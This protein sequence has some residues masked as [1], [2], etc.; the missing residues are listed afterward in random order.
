M[1]KILTVILAL[2]ALFV[3]FPAIVKADVKEENEIVKKV[4]MVRIQNHLNL[5]SV[6]DELTEKARIR[7]EEAAQKWSHTRPDGSEWSTIGSDG[8]NLCY[9]R[10]LS[11][12]VDLWMNSD[13]HR[14][15]ILYDGFSS[16]G[17]GIYEE[18]GVYYIAQE[19]AL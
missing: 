8:E 19:F 12:V 6:D 1:Y 15:N 5:L 7:A 16:M 10:D 17:I 13:S 11:L 14:D 18:N 4:E 3:L 9:T 2:L